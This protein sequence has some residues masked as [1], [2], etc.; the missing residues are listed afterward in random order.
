[1][2]ATAVM[3][4]AMSLT[5][6]A[7]GK[8]AEAGAGVGVG[9]TATADDKGSTPS[10]NVDFEVFTRESIVEFEGKKFRKIEYKKKVVYLQ[11]LESETS[12]G[13]LQVHCGEFPRPAPP[14]QIQVAVKVTKRSHLF[15]EGLRQVCENQQGGSRVVIDPAIRVGFTFEGSPKDILKNKKV[16]IQPFNGLGAGFSAEW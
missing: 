2:V 16:F 9:T 5:R 3:V 14:S 10:L 1:M 12:A 7:A 11:L 15:V 4:I 13:D 8:E 6:T